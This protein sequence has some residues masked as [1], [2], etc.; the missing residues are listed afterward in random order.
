M[1]TD[2]VA[3]TFAVVIAI[4][5]SGTAAAVVLWLKDRKRVSTET[6]TQGAASAVSSLERAV[7]RLEVENIGLNGKVDVLTRNLD[8]AL[9]ELQLAKVTN[10]ELLGKI[11]VLTKA[12]NDFEGRKN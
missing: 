5:S 3:L 6:V 1:E 10:H 8:T 2:V 12:L 9:Q 11:D 7:A 4:F